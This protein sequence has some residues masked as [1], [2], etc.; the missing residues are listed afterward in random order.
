MQFYIRHISIKVHQSSC[1]FLIHGGHN[2]DQ[3]KVE[4]LEENHETLVMKVST[5]EEKVTIDD[6]CFAVSDFLAFVSLLV[7]NVYIFIN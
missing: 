7:I 3:L 5:L 2:I 6:L 1:N 4:K